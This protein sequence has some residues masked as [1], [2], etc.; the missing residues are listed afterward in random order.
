MTPEQNEAFLDDLSRLVDGDP[1]A[2]ARWADVLADDDGARDLLHEARQAATF[3]RDAGAEFVLPADLEAR[4]LAAV[5]ASGADGASV[6]GPP[7]GASVTGADGASMTGPVVADSRAPVPKPWAGADGAGEGLGA[8]SAASDVSFAAPPTAPGSSPGASG[9]TPPTNAHDAGW[10]ASTPAI[11]T[12][13]ARWA[14]GGVAAHPPAPNGSASTGTRSTGAQAS[15]G[16]DVGNGVAVPLKSPSRF[17][18]FAVAAAA[19]ALI[20]GGVTYVAL[21]TTKPAGVSEPRAVAFEARV[22]AIATSVGGSGLTFVSAQGERPATE[23]ET[24]TGARLRTDART[25]ARLVLG[26]GSV[27]T[28]QQGSELAMG[29]GRLVELS[30]GE[31][32]FDVASVPGVAPFEVSTPAGRVEV[33]GTKF[34]V[35]VDDAGGAVRVLRGEVRVHPPTGAAVSLKAGQEALLR[36]S[37]AHV[38]NAVDLAGSVA[39]TELEGEPEDDLPIAGLG[40]LRAHRPGERE[41]QER[42]LTLSEHRVQVR[43]V[44]NVARTEIE[45]AFR[46]ESGDTLEGVYRFPLPPDARIASLSLEV[47]GQWEEGA[48]VAKDRAAAIWRGVIRNATPESQRRQQEE[49][50]WVPGP[51]R[52]PALLEWQQGGRFELR[53]FPIAARSERRV[54]IAYEQTLAPHGEG[55]RYVYPLAHASDDSTRVGHFEVDVRIAGD[56][57][58]NARGYELVPQPEDGAE[59]L[60]Y[61]RED[62]NPSGD[63]II[64]YRSPTDRGELR[65]WAFV[66]DAVAP[67]PERTREAEAVLREHR[68][69]ASDGRPYALF[70]LRPT[71]PGAIESRPRDYVVVVDASQSMF[72]ERYQRAV[73]LVRGMVGEMDRRDRVT[74]LACDALG[75]RALAGDPRVP[76]AHA[77]EQVVE[78]LEKE[79]PAGASDLTFAMREALAHAGRVG[80]GRERELQ[81]VYVGDGVATVGPRRPSSLAA[82]ASELLGGRA[83]LTTVGIG[84]EA[85]AVALAALARVGGGQYVPFVPGQSTGQAA[86]AVLEATYGVRLEKV[87][88]SFPEGVVG[89]APRELPTLRAGQEL[90]VAARLSREQVSG[91]VVLRGMVAGQRFEQR[92]PVELSASRSA[93]NAFVPRQWAAKTIEALE[94]AGDGADVPRLV[95]LSKGYGVMSRHTSLLVLESEAMFRAFGVDRGRASVQWTGEDPMEY[96]ESEG[97]ISVEPQRSLADSL[98]TGAGAGRAARAEAPASV[99]FS[100]A[101]PAMPQANALDEVASREMARRA[102]RPLGGQWMRK[103]WFR[104]GS[105]ARTDA[106]RDRDV[107]AVRAAEERLRGEPNSRDRHRELV[108]ALSRAGDVARAE[109]V[110][111]DWLARD[112]LDAEALT[113]LSDVVGRQGRRAEALRLLSGIVDLSPDEARFQERLAGAFERAGDAAR[114]CAHRVALAEGKPED[115]DAVAAAMRCER[116]LGRDAAA[117]RLL[118]LASSERRAQVATAAARAPTP[119]PIRGEV[120]LEGS[121]GGADV[122]LSLVTPEGTRLSW[123]GGRTTVVGDDAMRR[124]AERLG[125]RRATTGS[126]YV[127]VSRVDGDRSPV[128][129][130]VVITALGT[131][132]TVPF[133][134]VG[135]RA[136]LARVDVVRR[137]RMESGSGPRPR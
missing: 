99:G 85:D 105:V 37:A 1:D 28:V 25:R 49:W 67:P 114:A 95:A 62:F 75:C 6:T 112:R 3:V 130:H 33:I 115:V 82:E 46:N 70:S 26:D 42:P 97:T 11:P 73:R 118:A 128:R 45:E 104:E 40:E 43:I 5:G 31:A 52:D 2:L 116:G 53:I 56:A 101:S 86:L 8:P 106:V 107:A 63:L 30:R 80:A 34:L 9:A 54:R 69:L 133:E 125:L 78:L 93:G 35:T 39:W 120:L 51:W 71:L 19:L 88:L 129:G 124:G 38:V 17:A 87:E 32:L 100:M 103:V 81:I 21:D 23:G 134:L 44:G 76:G 83:R 136:T 132:Q 7:E 66:G 135:E 50:I 36:E 89:V 92:Y 68:N 108:R 102:P 20:A 64:D 10:A 117:E 126:Y 41:A 27:V 59:R 131:R 13:H 111:R 22:D 58:A 98:R 60:R 123:M 15:A 96:G 29:A 12:E 24:L 127:E 74:A 77:A 48:F 119:A 109:Q 18:R 113:Y 84:Q 47:D 57:Q 4:V 94:L 14:G 61:V 137:W 55:R 65:H 16:K 90:M 91:E 110:A 79:E 72:G 121:F 122:D